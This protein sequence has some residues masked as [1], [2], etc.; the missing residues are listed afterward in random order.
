MEI[1]YGMNCII[2]WTN[3][4]PDGYIYLFLLSSIGHQ[5]LQLYNKCVSKYI[6]K[7]CRTQLQQ[8]SI[9]IFFYLCS[10]YCSDASPDNI[11]YTF[12]Y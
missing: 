5:G 9:Y 7:D 8:Y 12:L 2:D 11:V 6:E 10:K 1:I 4:Q 3:S